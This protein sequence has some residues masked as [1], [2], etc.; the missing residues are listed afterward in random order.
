MSSLQSPQPPFLLPA[1]SFQSQGRR[2]LYY[3][4]AG[5]A[6]LLAL[7]A[8]WS[9]LRQQVFSSSYMPHFYCYLGNRSLVWSHVVTDSLIGTSYLALSVTLAHLVYRGRREIPFH[10][11]FLA[12]GLFIVACG[13]THFMEVVTV[14]D[15]VYVLSAI[16]KG[17][18]AVASVATAATLPFIVPKIL[19][20]VHKA[21]ESDQYLRFLESGLSEKEAAHGELRKINELL[22]AR[23]EQ[24][25]LELGKANEELQVSEKQYR[26]L[27]EGNPMPMWVF[28]RDS[29]RFL[30]VNQAAIRHYGYSRDEFLSMT[31]ADIRPDEDVPRLVNSVARKVPGLSEAELW[32]HRKKDGTI[33]QVEI[34]SHPI[35]M[36]GLDAEL[37]LSHDVTEQRK[38]QENL[39]QSEERFAT[40]FRSSPLAI[41]ISTEKEGEYV[42]ANDAF[43]KMMGYEREEIVGKTAHELRV[44]ADPEDRGKMLQP[45]G[46]SGRTEPLETRF[47]TKFGEERRVQVSAERILVDGKRCVLA[48]TLD[49]TESRLL[50]EQ[51]RQAQK[52]EAVGRLAGGVAHDFNNLLSV[53]MGY[54]ELAQGVTSP[55]TQLRKYVD[56]VKLAGER[57]ASV[58]RQLLAFSRQQVLEPKVL[59]LNAVVRSISQMLLRLIGEDVRLSL[60]PGEPLGSIKADL[61]QIEQVLMNLAVNA[62]DAMP[63]GGKILIETAN[64]ELDETYAR[65]HQ[66]V[67]PGS[68]VMLSFSDT[69]CGMDAKTMAQIFEPFFTTKEPG[70]GTGLGLSTV[71]GIV[72]QS[73]GYVWAYSEPMRGTTFKI[74]FPRIDGP[75]EKLTIPRSDLIFD[76][77]TETILL[78]EDDDAVRALIA[79]LLRGA[80]Y[81]VLEANGANT[82][83]E[84]AER[85]RNSIHLVL[86]DVIMPGMSGGDLIVHL[87]ALQL[88]LAILFMSGYASDLISR[89]GV[90]EPERFL[91]H[92]PFTRK[93]LLT[94]VRSMLNEAA[95]K[96]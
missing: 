19:L 64:V 41:T 82:A 11:M 57:A 5:C 67:K 1:P 26:L 24:R 69:G 74:Y 16:I 79:E 18:T 54:S 4:V 23:V 29:L 86:T 81:T 47:R 43:V 52:M 89:A 14:W 48:N 83:I 95:T 90:T 80:G 49:V 30:A 68:Y 76:R 84:V 96:F 31:I 50:E 40:A 28:H 72:K 25:T 88:N 51:F 3:G 36:D 27:F 22:E 7:F 55:G 15:P 42:D 78:V 85:H 10:W 65:Q 77:G 8:A 92:K 73:G 33:I 17:F 34:T 12:F 94:K 91:L 6:F 21:R 20:M 53:M 44:W 39:R 75:A 71:Y 13:L 60:T 37:I 45:L 70:K 93:S 61:G 58:T 56:Q 87:R 32:R 38:H 63:D 66:S 35:V 46:R 9:H 62:R 2:L 59:N